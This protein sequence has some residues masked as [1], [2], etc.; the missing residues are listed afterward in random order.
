MDSS[1]ST[2]APTTTSSSSTVDVAAHCFCTRCNRRMGSLKYAKHTLCLSC[3]DV[4]C[5]MDLRCVECTA[6]STDEMA[7]YL[8]HRKSLVSKGKKSSSVTTPSSSSP[9]VPPSATPI[10]A[11]S[12]PSPSLSSIADDEKIKQYVHSVLAN[13]LSQQSSQASLGSNPFLTAPLEVPDIPPPGSTGGRGSESLKRCRFASPTGVVPP[14]KDDDVMPP[15]NVCVPCTVASWGVASVPGSPFPPLGEFTPVSGAHD[16]FHSRGMSGFTQHVISADVHDVSC[17]VSSFDPSL[18][19]RSL[20]IFG[21]VFLLFLSSSFASFVI[22]CFFSSFLFFCSSFYSSSFLSSLGCS[23]C[24]S[25]S[26]HCFCSFFLFCSLFLCSF[27][28]RV[29]FFGSSCSSFGSSSCVALYSLF[30]PYGL[31]SRSSW[32]SSFGFDSLSSA[33][34]DDFAAVQ[35]RVL[36]LSAEYQ[37][38]ARWF[39]AS[40][41]L[42]F[43][44]ISLL[45]SL[46]STLTF[47]LISLLA[48][49]AS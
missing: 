31:G 45:I 19:F 6:W 8:C 10:V 23:I 44:R 49:P 2:T 12:S 22:F 5:A 21:L 17:S 33:S 25:F 39:F 18:L 15:I 43:W 42:I 41:V 36:G 30:F 7:E 13:L 1:P 11:T 16:Q 4:T 20:S 32:L 48:P 3:R 35:A 29:P 40:G 26:L 28:F 46:T 14:A 37:A 38:V 27:A 34:S 47:G 24:S 9:S